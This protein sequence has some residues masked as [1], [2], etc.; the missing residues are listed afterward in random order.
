[1][2]FPFKFL[3]LSGLVRFAELHAPHAIVTMECIF[4]ISYIYMYVILCMVIVYLY[5]YVSNYI[6]RGL[7]PKN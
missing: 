6:Y 5:V 7:K 2:T 4:I 3:S 1:V